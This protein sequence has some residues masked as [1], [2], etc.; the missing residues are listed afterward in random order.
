VKVSGTA[1]TNNRQKFIILANQRS[2]S[3]HLEY[4][5]DSHEAAKVAGEL[6]NPDYRLSAAEDL[7]QGFAALRREDPIAYIDKFFCQPFAEVTTHVGFR[8]F[9][10][11]GRENR[12][13]AIWA[14][15]QSMTN[16]K[17]IHLQRR[18]LLSNF[19]SLKLALKSK[20]WMRRKGQSVTNYQ[21]T[22]L[23][24]GECVEYFQTREHNIQ[25]S[26]HFFRRNPKIDIFYEDLASQERQQMACVL[27]FLRLKPQTLTNKI[28]KQN[29]QKPSELIS[30]YAQLKTSFRR[31]K[32]EHFFEE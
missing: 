6:F 4:L 26:R 13:E 12:E 9:Y 21:S 19:L 18:N 28:L 11:H 2:G 22:S 16:L 25:H 3:C 5:L 31:T 23:D 14:H 30:N 24:F 27:Q 15:L 17:V 20:I 7:V 29:H 1:V 10:D 32:W 8:L